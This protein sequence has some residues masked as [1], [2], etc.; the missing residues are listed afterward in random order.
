MFFFNHVDVLCSTK[1]VILLE[2]NGIIFV[3]FPIQDSLKVLLIKVTVLELSQDDV[4]F[5]GFTESS[6]ED[7]EIVLNLFSCFGVNFRGDSINVI[8]WPSSEGFD[9]LN[10]ISLRPIM[11]S[12]L[13]ILNVLIFQ[14][15]WNYF[16]V[17]LHLGNLQTQ[18]LNF[19]KVRIKLK[20]EDLLSQDTFVFLWSLIV[21]CFRS[22]H[23]F[24]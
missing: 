13:N 18:S 7:I 20:L 6:Q 24:V 11:K 4:S 17:V 23:W 12:L 14:S 1:V 19:V 5:F 22:C 10:V 8:D 21:E 3:L 2:K 9:E 16:E 15:I